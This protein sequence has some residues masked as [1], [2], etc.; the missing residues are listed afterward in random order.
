MKEMYDQDTA[1]PDEGMSKAK[2]VCFLVFRRT[3]GIFPREIGRYFRV[4]LLGLTQ[5][6][7]HTIEMGPLE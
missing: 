6:L 7:F 2:I 1:I 5:V 3:S 4:E